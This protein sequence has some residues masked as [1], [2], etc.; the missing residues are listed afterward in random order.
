MRKCPYCDF[1]S[2]EASQELPEQA[3]TQMLRQDLLH[4]RDQCSNQKIE[5]VFFGGGTPSLFSAQ[6]IG[7]I[8]ETANKIVG[9]S[10]DCEITLEANPGTFE[11][12][13]FNDYRSAGV[14]RLSIGIQSFSEQALKALGRIHSSDEALKAVATARQAGFDNI[15]LDLMFGLPGQDTQAAINDLR[16]AVDLQ[17]EHLSWYE[18][19]IEP[20]TAFYSRPPTLPEDDEVA[21]INDAGLDFLAGA[22]YQRYE[23]SAFAQEGRQCRHNLNYWQ[24]G[25]YLGIGAGAHGKLTLKDKKAIVRTQRNRMPASYLETP[26]EQGFTERTV[27]IDEQPFEFLMNALRLIDGVP[28]NFFIDRTFVIP[29]DIRDTLGKLREKGY[30]E[31]KTDKIRPSEH[32]LR[33][34]NQCLTELLPDEDRINLL[35]E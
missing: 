3:Y 27:P 15:N 17:P 24:F 25:D 12:Q 29:E 13:R 20:N 4:Y 18:L 30:L 34:L 8:L 31:P 11:Q 32:G 10:D 21:A 14:N 23:V 35:A 9:L 33:F 28:A 16:I 19:T 5:T 26:P 7:Q 22:G 2:H 6:A 1:N